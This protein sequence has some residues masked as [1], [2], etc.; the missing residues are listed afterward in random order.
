MVDF[1]TARYDGLSDRKSAHS[2]TFTCSNLARSLIFTL[3]DDGNKIS[4]RYVIVR[5]FSHPLESER[6]HCQCRAPRCSA[7]RTFFSICTLS[8]CPSTQEWQYSRLLSYLSPSSACHRR[9]RSPP[10]LK[11][12]IPSVRNAIVLKP[13]GRHVSTTITESC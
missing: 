7:S 3:A 10:P 12:C 13:S 9:I 6:Y 5:T 2:P 1:A 8:T 11:K 4:C